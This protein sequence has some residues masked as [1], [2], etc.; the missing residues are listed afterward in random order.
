MKHRTNESF[1]VVR[2]KNNVKDKRYFLIYIN[3][4]T[5]INIASTLSI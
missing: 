2:Y 1:V 3:D 5:K 4:Q